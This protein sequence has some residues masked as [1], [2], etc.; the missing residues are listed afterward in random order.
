MARPIRCH[1]LVRIVLSRLLRGRFGFAVL[2]SRAEARARSAGLLR[3]FVVYACPLRIIAQQL[4]RKITE[5]C[6]ATCKEPLRVCLRLG[7]PLD[8]TLFGDIDIADDGV[9][10]EISV[11]D[12]DIIILTPEVFFGSTADSIA[13]QQRCRT[14]AFCLLVIDE[15]S[16]VCAQ[17]LLLMSARRAT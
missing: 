7:R 9:D 4:L 8:S 3:P 15:V 12:A 6:S 2:L 13:V 14:T 16:T 5:M 17:C 10:N 1:R 11:Q